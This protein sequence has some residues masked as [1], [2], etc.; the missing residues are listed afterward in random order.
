MIGTMV[1][2]RGVKRYF[3][4]TSIRSWLLPLAVGL[5]AHDRAWR[6]SQVVPA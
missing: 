2:V 3:E 1:R 5:D 6:Y 4:P